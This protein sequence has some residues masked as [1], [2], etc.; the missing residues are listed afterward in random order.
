MRVAIA[1]AIIALVVLVGLYVYGLT[2]QPELR[3][4]ETDAI[5]MGAG[6]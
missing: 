1:I 3:Q 6:A 2:L 5:G 4:I